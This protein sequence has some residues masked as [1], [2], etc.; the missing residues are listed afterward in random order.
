MLIIKK[1]IEIKTKRSGQVSEQ[2]NIDDQVQL[3]WFDMQ[4]PNLSAVSNKGINFIVKAKFTH[5]HDQDILTCEDGY[6]IEVTRA[7]D[8]IYQLEFIDALT[9]AKAAYEIGNRHQ[10]ICITTNKITVLV[11]IALE[12]II[13]ALQKNKQVTVLKDTG[14]FKPNGKSHHS[15]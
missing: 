3:S 1:V 2:A 13:S 9:F 7:K 12:D 5:L 14:Y 6:L 4:K 11:D 10:P 8:E 15:H